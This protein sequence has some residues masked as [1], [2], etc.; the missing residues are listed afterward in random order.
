MTDL[1]TPARSIAAAKTRDVYTGRKPACID[2]Q[3]DRLR[4]SARGG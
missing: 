4:E 3:A 2:A 1:G